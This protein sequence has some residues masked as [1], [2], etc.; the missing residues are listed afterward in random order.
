MSAERYVLLGLAPARAPWFAA[1]AQWATSATIAAEFVKCVSADEVR[2][3]LG[4]GRR[5]SALLI[6]SGSR[7]FERDLVDAARGAHTPVIAVGDG[8]RGRPPHPAVRGVRVPVWW[9]AQLHWSRP[10]EDPGSAAWRPE[11]WGWSRS[12]PRISVATSC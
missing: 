10:Q 1:L 8:G 5:Y 12:C 11:T 3:R 2:A 4:S 9:R 6:D 7:W